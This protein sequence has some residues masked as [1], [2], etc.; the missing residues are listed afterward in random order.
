MTNPFLR[1]IAANGKIGKAGRQSEKAVAKKLGGSLTPASGAGQSKGDI[2]LESFM[3]ECKSTI[4]DSIGLKR[5]WLLKV[6][7]EALSA[8]KTPALSL[9]F[10]DDTGKSKQHGDWICIPSHVF[11]EIVENYHG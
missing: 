8:G 4:N 11:K 9:T 2:Q 5:E 7:R 6:A 1:R 10:T 3:I